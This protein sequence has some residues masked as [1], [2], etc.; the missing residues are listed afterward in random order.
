MTLS[1]IIPAFNEAA[2][3]EQT[4]ASARRAASALSEPFEVIVV[5]DDSSDQT[6]ALAEGA[7]ARV[8]RSGHRQIAATRNAGAAAATGDWLIFIDADTIVHS[9]TLQ[10]ARQ[11]VGNGF[12]AGGASIT[13]SEGAGF[14]TRMAS[15]AWNFMARIFHW[16]A[17]SFVF[18]RREAFDAIGGF[19]TRYYA[20][21]EIHLSRA[22]HRHAGKDRFAIVSPP[23]ITSARKERLYSWAEHFTT[24]MKAF[25]TRGK[26]LQKREGL[27][28]WY[29]G[30]RESVTD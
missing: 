20:S 11:A 8:V 12:V 17:G 22:L 27:E 6:V 2:L 7:G 30:K 15:K 4:V 10:A 21:E 29:E 23:V 16:A 3:I 24:A 9:R 5:D 18:C 28:L 13:F 14:Y 25:L 26:S 19:D 1:I